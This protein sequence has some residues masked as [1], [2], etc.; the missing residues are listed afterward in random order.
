M[1]NKKS[2]SITPEP[3]EVKP[4]IRRPKTKREEEEER[5]QALISPDRGKVRKPK[6]KGPLS[7]GVGFDHADRK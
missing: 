6:N 5:E 2:H 3:D 1:A 4:R 7:V